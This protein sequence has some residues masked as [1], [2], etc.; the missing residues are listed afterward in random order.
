MIE[1]LFGSD[2]YG[3]KDVNIA[4]SRMLTAGVIMTKF[5]GGFAPIVPIGSAT[6]GTVVNSA[7]TLNEDA[8]KVVPQYH[9]YQYIIRDGSVIMPSGTIIRFVGELTTILPTAKTYVY[10]SQSINGG[11][12]TLKKTSEP[13]T[14]FDVPLALVEYDNIRD[15]R[16]PAYSRLQIPAWS[17]STQTSTIAFDVNNTEEHYIELSNMNFS[18]C[19]MVNQRTKNDDGLPVPPVLLEYKYKFMGYRYLMAYYVR[20]EGKRIYIKTKKSGFNTLYA[21][22]GDCNISIF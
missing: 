10:L 2:T 12:V 13:P 16:N 8:C 14:E 11:A 20:R 6:A 22:N 15:M 3:A 7:S 1:I 17:G 21:N 5:S 19:F 9:N 18:H 4:M